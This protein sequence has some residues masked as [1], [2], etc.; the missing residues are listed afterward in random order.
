M[1]HCRICGQPA[2]FMRSVHKECAARRDRALADINLEFSDMMRVDI[3]PTPAAFRATIQKLGDE[4]RLSSA[5]LRST[6]L[7][8]LSVSLEAALADFNLSQV[9]IDRFEGILDAFNLDATALD[10]AGIRDRLVKA[11]VLKDLSEGRTSNRIT[12]NGSLPIVL[13]RGEAIQWLFNN[14][15]LQ[16]PRTRVSYEGGSRGVSVRVMKGVSYRVGSYKG[17]RVDTTEVVTVGH[18]EF[19]VSNSAVYFL[20][21]PKTRKTTLSSIVSVDAYDDGIVISPSR[22]KQQIY[23][24]DDPFFASNLILKAGALA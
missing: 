9:E 1:G 5:E 15:A 24:L 16:E 12:V 7:S 14:V 11:L 19:A 22:G 2:G 8:G 13:K 6:I 18:G 23:L 21:P 20:C 10:E 4:A 3:A 17:R